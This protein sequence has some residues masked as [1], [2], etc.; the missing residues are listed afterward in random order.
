MN[1]VSPWAWIILFGAITLV[2]IYIFGS[3]G[4]SIKT[5]VS[6]LGWIITGLGFFTFVGGERRRGII[7]IIV[8]IILVNI[9]G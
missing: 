2:A 1:K 7:A 9:S 5:I 4:I 3:A 8:G 6:F